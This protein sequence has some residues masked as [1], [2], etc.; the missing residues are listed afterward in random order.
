M[1][2]AR[3]EI[4]L[5]NEKDVVFDQIRNLLSSSKEFE[6]EL[7]EPMEDH[8]EAVAAFGKIFRIKKKNRKTIWKLAAV[9][10]PTIGSIITNSVA[11]YLNDEPAECIT[12]NKTENNY[13][14][15]I[16]SEDKR[17]DCESLEEAMKKVKQNCEEE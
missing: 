1:E 5:Q 11:V 17:E 16:V 3:Y 13:N 9:L 12:V 7:Y 8:F 2:T 15:I 4:Y 10:L 14:I 6:W